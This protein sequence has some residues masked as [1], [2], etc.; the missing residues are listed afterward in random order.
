MDSKQQLQDLKDDCRSVGWDG[1]IPAIEALEAENAKLRD[2]IAAWRSPG[3]ASLTELLTSADAEN[4][5]LRAELADARRQERE[6]CAQECDELGQA[7]GVTCAKELRCGMPAIYGY[8][9]VTPSCTGPEWFGA[10]NKDKAGSYSH[11]PSCGVPASVE[12]RPVPKAELAARGPVLGVG[13]L[14]EELFDG[15]AVLKAIPEGKH[16]SAD[17]VAVVLDAVVALIRNRT[18]SNLLSRQGNLERAK[19]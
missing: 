14:P 4:A 12:A 11:C 7:D 17:H 16:V 18:G 10:P 9:C 2:D 1:Y 8:H 19:R 3:R 5:A 15:Y 13:D 6:L